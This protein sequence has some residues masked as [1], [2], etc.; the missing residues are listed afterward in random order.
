MPNESEVELFIDEDGTLTIVHDE[1][2]LEALG[3]LGTIENK[4][5]S[6][7]EPCWPDTHEWYV[8]L[9]PTTHGTHLYNGLGPFQTRKE[10]LRV[11]RLWLSH[12]LTTGENLDWNVASQQLVVR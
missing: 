3:D 10:A 6:L 11:E 12:Y 4:R 1:N 5:A 7:V 9:S 2:M 8:D